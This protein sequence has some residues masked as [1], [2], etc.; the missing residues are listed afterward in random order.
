VP[1]G[2]RP[3]DRAAINR[4]STIEAEMSGAR[5]EIERLRLLLAKARRERF[6]QSAERGAR[7]VEQL[8]L[9]LAELE[10]TVAEEDAAAELAAPPVRPETRARL[11]RKPARRPLPEN[12]PRERIVYPAPCSCPK[13]G[14]PVRKLGE[15]VTESLECEPRLEGGRARA[16]EGFLPLL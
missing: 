10:E 11:G 9:Q 13:C 12:L 16:G 4:A 1:R 2:S 6:G 8:E 14:G 15:D 7:L 5:L 3:V